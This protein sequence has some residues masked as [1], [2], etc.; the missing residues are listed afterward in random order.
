MNV[1]LLEAVHWADRPNV[2][3]KQALWVFDGRGGRCCARGAGSRRLAGVGNFPREKRGTQ[4]VGRVGW[5]E[6]IRSAR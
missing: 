2:T 3:V 1:N 5:L 4:T 6:P